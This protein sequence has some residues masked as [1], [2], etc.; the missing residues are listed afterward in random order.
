M[1]Q[2]LFILLYIFSCTSILAQK[3][4]RFRVYTGVSAGFV[5]LRLSGPT[6]IG[7]G[8][9][10]STTNSTYV[11]YPVFRNIDTTALALN[12]FV[13][14]G[15][16]IPVYRSDNWSAGFKLSAGVGYQMGIKA[17]EGLSSFGFDFPQFVY[18]R[19]YSGNID[20]SILAGWK[21]SYVALPY[22]LCLLGAEINFEESQLRFYFSPV[23]YT[24][25]REYT[26]GRI[27]PAAKIYEAGVG[28]F[29]N[30]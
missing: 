4:D 23:P 12:F 16:N 1:K 24:Y 5:A 22:Q 11:S 21:Y 10:S 19:R 25:Y 28:Y 2:L 27:E 30:F 6:D 20:Y 3:T 7:N 29:Y 9:T 18:Y 13:P 8:G 17:A 26:N 15:F 14:L